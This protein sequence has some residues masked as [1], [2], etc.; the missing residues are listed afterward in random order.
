M[1]KMI[2]YE[3]QGIVFLVKPFNFPFI[4]PLI[5]ALPA[6]MAGNKVLLK[7]P[8]CCPQVGL[9]L[10]EVFKAAGLEGYFET[11][12]VPIPLLEKVISDPR[13]KGV[14]VTGHKNTGK[15]IASLAGKYM[16][17]IVC[18]LGGS[19]PF[20]VLDDANLE[21]AV[22]SAIRARLTNTG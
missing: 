3:P 1:K 2:V 9:K 15:I 16:K 11:G 20:V 17:K 6:L 12:F 18:E 21:N 4:V 22:E 19:D 5:S 7:P 14:H 10:A 13:V 8:E